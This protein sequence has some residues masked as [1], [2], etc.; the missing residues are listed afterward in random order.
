LE[1]FSSPFFFQYRPI[2]GGERHKWDHAW[3]LHRRP[4]VSG[5]FTVLTKNLLNIA[6][7]MHLTE[8]YTGIR[9]ARSDR[10]VLSR[11][12]SAMNTIGSP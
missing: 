9:E 1:F 12:R 5:W 6:K 11:S 3:I 4:E 2:R 7:D 10:K 8:G